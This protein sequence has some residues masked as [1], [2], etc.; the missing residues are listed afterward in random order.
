MDLNLPSGVRISRCGSM[1]EFDLALV[2]GIQ[3]IRALHM[4]HSTWLSTRLLDS[5]SISIHFRQVS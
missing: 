4:L 3:A 1:G 5:G 2:A